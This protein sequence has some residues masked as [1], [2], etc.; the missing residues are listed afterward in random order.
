[1]G[2]CP[3][4]G[5]RGPSQPHGCCLTPNH[6]PSPQV[7]L[8]TD[9]RMGRPSSCA[10]ASGRGWGMMAMKPPLWAQDLP[11]P[12]LFLSMGQHPKSARG[13]RR[14]HTRYPVSYGCSGMG[15]LGNGA[16][17]CCEQPFLGCPEHFW[18]G[19]RFGEPKSALFI[20]SK[21]PAGI[22]LLCNPLGDTE[23]LLPQGSGTTVPE[24]NPQVCPNLRGRFY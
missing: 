21:V 5:G 1:M 18:D 16:G 23:P 9:P 7:L 20:V 12:C 22:L 2:G 8:T 4:G 13:R 11:A 10:S 15:A 17:G 19:Q 14:G 6:C 3:W 24:G